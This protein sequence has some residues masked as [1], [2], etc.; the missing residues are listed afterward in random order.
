M[1]FVKFYFDDGVK[2]AS[3]LIAMFKKKIQNQY[4]VKMNKIYTHVVILLLN[5]A[6]TN[7]VNA[8]QK[9][10][11]Y[12]QSYLGIG[13]G[14]DYGGIGLK[15]EFLPVKWLGI[16]G[17]AGYNLVE[18]AYNI[19]LSF[20]ILPDKKVTPTITAMYG[21]NAVIKIIGVFGNEIRNQSYYGLSVGAGAE[22]K[23]GLNKNKLSLALLVPFRNAAFHQ[24]YRTHKNNGT[25]FNPDILPV[26]ITF[27][28]NFGINP[29]TKK[30]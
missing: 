6:L 26:A 30:K 18:P 11:A 28:V 29:K 13:A 4:L 25:Q 9:K 23:Y 3:N 22:M 1:A 7:K 21:Y 17:S 27:G 19:G 2:N 16:F 14:F 12:Q 8:Q 24:D 5:M 10:P 15:G 20:K